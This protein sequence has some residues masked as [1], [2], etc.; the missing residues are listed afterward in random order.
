M[1]SLSKSIEDSRNKIIENNKYLADLQTKITEE[2]KKLS[3]DIKRKTALLTIMKECENDEGFLKESANLISSLS[4]S[5]AEPPK[6][7]AR[8]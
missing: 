5:E 2:N 8:K 3:A 6:T 7:R 4:K 1:D